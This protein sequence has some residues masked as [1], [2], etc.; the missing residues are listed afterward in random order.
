MPRPP[1]ERSMVWCACTNRSKIFGSMSAGMPMPWSATRSTASSPSRPTNTLITPSPRVNLSAFETRLPTICSSRTGSPLTQTGSETRSMRPWL[2]GLP[3]AMVAI[4]DL[5]ALREVHGRALQHDLAGHRAADVE[6]VVDEAR[7]V[8]HL[9]LDDAGGAQRHGSVWFIS[10]S[11]CTAPWIAPSGLR[12][13]CA[14]IARNSSF[15]RFSRCAR[16]SELMSREDQRA[17]LDVVEHDARQRHLHLGRFLAV[18]APVA[19]GSAPSRVRAWRAGFRL[20]PAAGTC[21][22]RRRTPARAACAPGPRNAGC[23]RRCRRSRESV[24]APSCM[25]STSAR[26]GASALRSVNTRRS[27][28]SSA[29]SNASISPL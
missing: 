25:R 29:S 7:H 18:R 13:S 27:P 20:R 1:R 14:S 17:M 10:A 24:A 22:S 11:A 19:S 3:E 21:R 26:Y 12:S 4:D 8:H 5:T 16:A 2:L 9:A 15:E 6:Q 23:S 28:F